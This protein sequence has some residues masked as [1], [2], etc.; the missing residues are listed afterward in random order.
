[1]SNLLAKYVLQEGKA[2]RVLGRDAEA[3]P[4]LT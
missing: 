1:L 4:V 2:P 3:N